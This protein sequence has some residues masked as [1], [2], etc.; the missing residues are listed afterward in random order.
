MI[1][2]NPNS[3]Y[4]FPTTAAESQELQRQ[5]GLINNAI[6]EVNQSPILAL[7]QQR[8]V[9]RLYLAPDGLGGNVLCCRDDIHRGAIVAIE[10]NLCLA[11]LKAKASDPTTKELQSHI[12][13]ALPTHSIAGVFKVVLNGSHIH[14]A[15]SIPCA[16]EFGNS[17][18]LNH[19][20]GDHANCGY[21]HQVI[22][23]AS[24]EL[25]LPY[26][27]ALKNIP[28]DTPLTYQYYTEQATNTFITLQPGQAIPANMVKCQCDPQCP[29][30]LVRTPLRDPSTFVQHSIMV[31]LTGDVPAVYALH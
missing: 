24:C 12:D 8:Q 3:A 23:T 19:A 6:A 21:R 7:K 11:H 14:M 28:K 30:A 16:W 1:K 10:D 2:L 27:V 31:D 5:Q 17:Y 9:P 15:R 29:N 22:R 26:I 18:F 20:C 4:Y 25:G 13:A